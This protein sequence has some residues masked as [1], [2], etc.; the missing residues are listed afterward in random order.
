[1]VPITKKKLLA[2]EGRDEVVFFKELLD[3][4]GML[5]IVDFCEVKGKDNFKKEMPLLTRTTGF[6]DLEAVAIIRDADDSH[7]SAF[8]SVKGVLK[9]N[10]LQAPERPGEFSQVNWG[11]GILC[12]YLYHIRERGERTK[13][14]QPAFYSSFLRF[15]LSYCLI[16]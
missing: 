8:E 13:W 11:S 3:H 7:K 5:D 9:E 12:I 14:T 1:M 6:N 10:S 15:F 2:V 16:A 4:M